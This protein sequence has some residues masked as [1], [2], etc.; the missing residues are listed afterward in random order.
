VCPDA[1]GLT[2]VG[3]TFQR[4]MDVVFMGKT[5]KFT[6]IYLDDLTVF[7]DSDENC[8]KHLSKVFDR[9]RKF[10]IS[11]NPKKSLF[12]IKEGKLLGI[13]SQRMES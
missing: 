2:N 1:I 4:A 6:V 8:L 13:L 7:S 9:C 12:S 10:G 5:S 11:L 3:T